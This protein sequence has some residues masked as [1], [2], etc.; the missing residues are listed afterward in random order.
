MAGLVPAVHALI[1][2]ISKN[3]DARD[4]AGHDDLLQTSRH[5]EERW[6]RSN[7]V[8]ACGFLDCFA[9]LAMTAN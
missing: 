9:L 7:P 1:K 6:R 5:C 8:L 3:V 2:P 4:E